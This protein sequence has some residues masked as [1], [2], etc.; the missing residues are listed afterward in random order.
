MGHDA[1]TM[2]HT[3]ET[4]FIQSLSSLDGTAFED[5]VCAFLRKCISDFQNVP[6]KPHGDAG[7]DGLSSQQTIAYCCYGPE[8]ASSQ[9][10]KTLKTNII[11]K[12]RSDLMSLFELAPSGR[13]KHVHNPNKEMP[14]ILT[15]GKKIKTI[16]LVVNNF[17]SHRLLS[18]LTTTF[19]NFKKTSKCNYIDPQAGLTIWG[20]KELASTGA[21]DDHT[22]LRLEG[23]AMMHRVKTTLA[24]SPPPA[25]SST[26]F[27]EKF[28]WVKAHGKPSTFPALDRLRNHF[29]NSWSEGIAIEQDLANNAVSLHEALSQIRLLASVDADIESGTTQGPHALLQSMR[30]KLRER[31]REHAGD[32]LP[33]QILERLAD[34]EVARLLG[35]CPIDWR[36]N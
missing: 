36:N 24:V 27:D 14:T 19:E 7:L 31:L 21:V 13:N 5:A 18:P 8:Q 30:E 26:D 10:P 29:R 23:A 16:R 22:L 2:P 35:E 1:P 11:N 9:D 6:A 17:E 20:P 28:D 15:P 3:Q 4:K 33:P 12:F 34:S 25:P 32:I